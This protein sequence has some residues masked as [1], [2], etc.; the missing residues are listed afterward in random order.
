MIILNGVKPCKCPACEYEFYRTADRH[1]IAEQEFTNG[2]IGY[3][4]AW[5]CPAC[6][7]QCLGGRRYLEYEDEE[8]EIESSSKPDNL[9]IIDEFAVRNEIEK[10]E[11]YSVYFHDKDDATLIIESMKE[12]LDLYG[13]VTVADLNDFMGRDSN[14]KD[15]R[16]G[17]TALGDV[18]PTVYHSYGHDMCGYF[19][20]KFPKPR[21][22]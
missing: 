11:Y 7:T 15:S 20:V 12:V 18:K 10:E 17:W 19:V 14:Y 16:V 21:P 9:I 4:D 22:I 13:V 3:H 6:G 5:D 8:A 2:V 1:Y